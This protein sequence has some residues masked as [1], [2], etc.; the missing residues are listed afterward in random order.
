MLPIGGAIYQE[1]PINITGIGKF[2]TTKR[3]EDN[4]TGIGCIHAMKSLLQFHS[5]GFSALSCSF[6]LA[7][8][9]P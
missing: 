5:L 4:H 2:V 9:C 8:I 3:T 1:R 6:E 7:P